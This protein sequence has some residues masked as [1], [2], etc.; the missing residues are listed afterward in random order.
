MKIPRWRWLFALLLTGLLAESVDLCHAGDTVASGADPK[1]L[2][3]S[4]ELLETKNLGEW[5][6]LTGNWW[7]ARDAMKQHGIVIDSS[8]TQFYQG[9]VTGGS[10]LEGRYGGKW[11]LYVYLDSEGMGLWKGGKLQVHAVDWQFGQNSNLDVVGLAPVNGALVTPLIDDATY[12]LTALM[13]EQSLPAGFSLTFGRSNIFDTWS[14]LYPDYGRGVDGFMN[15]A[16]L[17]PMNAPPSLP[18]ITNSAGL[19]QGGPHGLNAAFFVM[20]SQ[21]SPTTIGLDF[22]NGV[23]FMGLARYNSNFGNLRGTH[24]IMGAGATQECV[25]GQEG[26]QSRSMTSRI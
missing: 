9:A 15:L 18:F 26:Q 5:D 6:R 20:D 11:D 2:L 1:A 3:N 12:A 4:S 8:V 7:G 14:Q 21:N 24:T 23:T 17:L 22:P 13:F 16:F 25:A 10:E 19:M